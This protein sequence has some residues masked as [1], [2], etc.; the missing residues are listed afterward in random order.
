MATLEKVA[1]ADLEK[2]G[3]V[4]MRH[5]KTNGVALTVKYI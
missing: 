4:C 5:F 1:D 2:E 3:T